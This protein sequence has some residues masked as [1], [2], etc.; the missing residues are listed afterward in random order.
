MIILPYVVISIDLC[1][2][3]MDQAAALHTQAAIRVE[4][5]VGGTAW[6]VGLVPIRHSHVTVI[7]AIAESQSL[8][9]EDKQRQS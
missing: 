9:K 6:L 7:M 8:N 2:C 1:D 5:D 4:C 3:V